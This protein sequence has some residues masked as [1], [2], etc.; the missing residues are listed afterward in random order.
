M[1][2]LPVIDSILIAHLSTHSTGIWKYTEQ[3]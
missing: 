3:K 2:M 1:R